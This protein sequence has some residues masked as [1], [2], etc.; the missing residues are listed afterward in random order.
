MLEVNPRVADRAVL[1]KATGTPLEGCAKLMIG[2]WPSRGSPT[3]S[4]CLDSSSRR[5]PVREVPGVDTLLGPEM[6]STGEI[7]GAPT[8]GSAFVKAYMGAGQR[9]L[10]GTAFISATTTTSSVRRLRASSRTSASSQA[11]RGARQRIA[12]ARPRRGHHL[13]GQRGRPQSAKL[14]NRRIALVINTP[15]RRESFF[16]VTPSEPIVPGRAVHRSGR[17]GGRR[18]SRSGR[19]SSPSSRCRNTTRSS[20]A[21]RSAHPTMANASELPAGLAAFVTERFVRSSGPGGQN[22]N[23][24]ATAV[25][26]RFDLSASSL[27]DEVK[28][29]LRDMAGHRLAADGAVIID[30]REYRRARI[31]ATS[32]AV[33]GAGATIAPRFPARRPTSA[34]EQT[35]NCAAARSKEPTARR[36]SD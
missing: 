22:V 3:T 7:M 28:T 26:L 10:R 24:V 21:A 18:R 9:L 34:R 33:V 8:F 1:S 6:K 36:R 25:E 2:N 20:P 17:V 16:D 32:R 5:L 15:A 30:A 27:S 19:K 13:Q 14:L 12:R 35:S 29:R 31:E 4:R 11:T 23:K